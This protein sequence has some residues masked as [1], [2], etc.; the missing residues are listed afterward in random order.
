MSDDVAAQGSRGGRP[1][2]EEAERIRDRILDVATQLFLEQGYGATSIEAVAQRLR[3]SKRTFYH[4]FRDKAELFEAVVHRIVDA[5]RPADLNP[6]F[7]GDNAEEVLLRLAGLAMAMPSWRPSTSFRWWCR[8]RS[9][10]PW[11]W[12]R[13]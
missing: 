8:S 3:M 12:E 13:R 1:S 5:L 9:A 7:V 2:R 10:A 4:R 6:L 11:A